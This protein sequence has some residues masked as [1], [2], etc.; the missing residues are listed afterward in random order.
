M[1]RGHVRVNKIPTSLSKVVN[2]YT[3][4]EDMLKA[5]KLDMVAIVTPDHF[6]RC[7]TE[8]VLNSRSHLLLTQPI[9]T[10]LDDAK[11]IIRLSE[12]LDLKLMVAH[13]A[14]FRSNFKRTKE[15]VE[16]GELGELIYIRL[17]HLYR[18]YK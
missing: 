17:N 15:I 4:L 2:A 7:H 1:R 13:E 12:S 16:R 6:H 14:R 11:A 18:K 3:K 9:S 8:A 5:E 10:N